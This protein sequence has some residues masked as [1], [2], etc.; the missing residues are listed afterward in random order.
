MTGKSKW[1]DQLQKDSV[2]IHMKGRDWK[3]FFPK[4][5]FPSDKTFSR[6]VDKWKLI[7]LEEYRQDKIRQEQ[8]RK[9]QHKTRTPRVRQ[10]E[11]I[12]I[13]MKFLSVVED[14]AYNWLSSYV[15]KDNP[16]TVRKRAIVT[17]IT[18]ITKKEVDKK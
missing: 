2:E 17:K 14:M 16:A 3:I 1:S 4:G 15:N 7:I 11:Y 6:W 8:T 9:G 10:D 18:E 13:P 5:D 12:P